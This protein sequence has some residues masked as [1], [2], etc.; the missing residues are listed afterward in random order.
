M[1]KQSKTA[2]E[3]RDI[4]AARLGVGDV[5]IAVYK[6]RTDGW[7]ATVLTTLQPTN[8]KHYQA[9]VD[10]IVVELR[11]EYDLAE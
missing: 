8:R 6:D 10:Q 1:A 2:R 11:K 9:S 7:H 3:L 4:V 5:L